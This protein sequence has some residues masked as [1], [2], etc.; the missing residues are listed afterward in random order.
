[1]AG[2]DDGSLQVTGSYCVAL[3][4]ALGTAEGQ[5]VDRDRVQFLR[6]PLAESP[7]SSQLLPSLTIESLI[8]VGTGTLEMPRI[9]E[10]LSETPG[11][12]CGEVQLLDNLDAPILKGITGD[13]M[14]GLKRVFD[15][16][17]RLFWITRGALA[18]E[19]YHPIVSVAFSRVIRAEAPHVSLNVL[20][21]IDVK[22]P[23]AVSK[24][25][26][27][28]LLRQVTLD[29]WETNRGADELLWP[30]ERETFLTDGKHAFRRIVKNVD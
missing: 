22:N 12:F 14:E 4:V 13:K 26:A 21:M 16:T 2:V 1:M 18:D 30:K 23:A 11:N 19:P 29:E 15:L 5:V 24:F 17:K 10:E 7:A 8:I 27:E 28:H 20:D 25:I 6:R 9:A 3:D